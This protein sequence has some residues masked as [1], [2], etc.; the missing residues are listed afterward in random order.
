MIR[1]SSC[2]F[3]KGFKISKPE[4]TVHRSGAKIIM[5]KINTVP[6][7]S[8][9]IIVPGGTIFENDKNQGISNLVSRTLM[10]DSKRF[11]FNQIAAI[12]DSTASNF[13][14]FSGRNSMGV[15]IE[16]MKP[17][18]KKM[19]D[20]AR[21]VI[22]YPQFNEQYF[23]VEKKVIEDE[24]KS[25]EDNLARYANTL[26]LKTI[27]QK[28]PYRLDPQG[29]VK[30][31]RSLTRKGVRSFYYLMLDPS[32]MIFS[33]AGDFDKKHILKWVDS[34]V[35]EMRTQNK[36]HLNVPNEPVQKSPRVS[37]FK[38]DSKQA[39]IFL[40]YRTC[41][42]K[43][44]DRY[45]LKVLSSALSGQSG[46]LFINLRDK[47]SLAYTVSP[48]DMYGSAPGYFGVYIASETSKT[49]KAIEEIRK[50]LNRVRTGHVDKD[51]LERA[52]NFIIGRHAIGMQA[53]SEQTA[54]MGFDEFYGLGFSS[55]FN[56]SDKIMKV[57]AEDI[58]KVAKKYFRDSGEN[59]VIVS[60]DP[61]VL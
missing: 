7:I 55:A 20:V 50:E 48:V 14:A 2:N 9:R 40:A 38:K 24:I 56:Y 35:S 29:T 16:V 15:S 6:L 19:L 43:S 49:K 5:R 36:K 61:K 52:K 4:I 54:N 33:V 22:L 47:Q 13:N 37:T 59:V 18:A 31:V 25:E 10:F 32:K 57:S 26:L 53:Y 34:V 12:I 21:D 1:S 23:D 46:R 11:S 45:P 8:I 41:D 58:I 28:H 3:D 60:N 17:F 51:E 30:S 42:I 39:H 27:Y 44:P